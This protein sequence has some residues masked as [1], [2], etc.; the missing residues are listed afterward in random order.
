[1]IAS[2]DTG[3]GISS[4]SRGIRGWFSFLI[5]LSSF[6]FVTVLAFQNLIVASK[7]T[8]ILRSAKYAIS[9]MIPIVGSTVSGALA[10]LIS[11][12]K[13]LSVSIGAVS[14]LVI[15]SVMGAPLITLLFYRLCMGACIT[16]TSFSGAS[17]A[18]RFFTSLRGAID[19]VIAVLASSVMVYVLQ[20]IVFMKSFEGAF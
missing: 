14:V 18:E 2:F 19:T 17:Y 10:T 7:D 13:Y 1:L 4:V 3:Q 5:G 9:G 11:G 8:V 6:V 20:I 16:L 12:V 15:L